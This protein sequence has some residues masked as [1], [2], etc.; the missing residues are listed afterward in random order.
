[1]KR[2]SMC[3]LSL[4]L[5]TASCTLSDVPEGECGNDALRFGDACIAEAE[6]TGSSKRVLSSDDRICTCFTGY[7]YIYDDCYQAGET[8]I[9]GRYPQDEDSD[10]PLPLKWR[11]LEV[12]DDSAL[13][14][15]EY[16]LE[17]SPYHDQQEDI[18]WEWSN[19]RS[20]LNGFD[21][22][23]NKN[24]IDHTGKGFIDRAF[25]ADDRKRIKTVT[26]KNPDAP[27]DWNSTPGG[28]D[29]ED[30]VFLLSY[31]EVFKFFPT[32]KSRIASPTAYALHPPTSSG[33]NNLYTCPIT[34]SADNSC[35]CSMG[36][37]WNNNALNVQL[38][39]NIQCCSYWWLRSPGTDPEGAA[40]VY[41]GGG[42][43]NYYDVDDIYLGL[44]PALYVSLSSEF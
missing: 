29:T 38:C 13:L 31:D 15:S 8:L 17:Q 42:V 19:V 36:T 40:S 16:I 39:S 24:G 14:I 6:C 20:Y 12:N 18:T 3:L 41:Y 23:H 1:M 11:I 43:Y 44:R 26:N 4:G 5:V 25:T 27:A 34:C 10:T 32:N 22:S 35:G 33:R 37:T 2:L 9:F 28:N 7:T 21:G 30:K